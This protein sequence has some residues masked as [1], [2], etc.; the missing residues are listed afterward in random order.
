MLPIQIFHVNISGKPPEFKKFP[1]T[2]KMYKTGETAKLHC[3]STGNP[4]P[5]VGWFKDGKSYGVDKRTSVGEDGWSLNLRY[6]T[7]ADS[8]NYTCRVSN[9][10][11]SIN[12]TFRVVVKGRYRTVAKL[13]APDHE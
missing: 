9:N 10:V 1:K 7:V 12:R 8:G 11:G 4:D 6:L 5:N 13:I 3:H 2:R